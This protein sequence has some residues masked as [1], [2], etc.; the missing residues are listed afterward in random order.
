MSHR[1]EIFDRDR[2]IEANTSPGGTRWRGQDLADVDV[3]VVEATAVLRTVVT[4]TV[5]TA[6]GGQ[7]QRMPMTQTWVREAGRWRCLAGH[8]G[9]R[10][11]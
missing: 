5:F 6:Q 9:P 8:A 4:D 7:R 2:Y 10:L 11:D 1:G 3:V